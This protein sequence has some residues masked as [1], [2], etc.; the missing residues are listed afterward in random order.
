M[1]DKTII[2]FAASVIITLLASFRTYIL[3]L[4]KFPE[5]FGLKDEKLESLTNS[6]VKNITIKILIIIFGLIQLFSIV[7]LT[8]NYLLFEKIFYKPYLETNRWFSI[9]LACCLI[10]HF[11]TCFLIY[12]KV[13]FKIWKRNIQKDQ[14]IT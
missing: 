2:C 1:I 8:T 3:V 13:K 11:I 7:L 6:A 9:T 14:N 10:L 4:P 5:I 12:N